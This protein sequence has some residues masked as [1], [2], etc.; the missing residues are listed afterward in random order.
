MII[1]LNLIQILT[2]ELVKEVENSITEFR[3]QNQEYDE[4]R[5]RAQ[6]I[7]MKS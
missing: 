7:A 4:E 1:I 5:V 6:V 3:R 2:D